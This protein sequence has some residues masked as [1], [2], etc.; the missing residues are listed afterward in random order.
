VEKS[1]LAD[2]LAQTRESK[3]FANSAPIRLASPRSAA[4][5]AKAR[6]A[7]PHGLG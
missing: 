1:A 4:A 6:A 5:S 7:E 3:V 2:F